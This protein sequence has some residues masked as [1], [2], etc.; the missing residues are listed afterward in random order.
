MKN[1]LKTLTLLMLLLILSCTTDEELINDDLNIEQA[2]LQVINTLDVEGQ[3]SMKE[4]DFKIISDNIDLDKF[5]VTEKSI[6]PC[7]EYPNDVCYYYVWCHDGT[8]HPL[9]L[10]KEECALCSCRESC[11]DELIV[12]INPITRDPYPLAPYC[13]GPGGYVLANPDG[14]YTIYQNGNP[15]PITVPSSD[16]SFVTMTCTKFMSNK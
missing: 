5:N 13:S 16:Q 1:Y 8:G 12:T 3:I 14:S 11:N 7:K 15:N 4:S 9:R 2:T 6:T 10:C